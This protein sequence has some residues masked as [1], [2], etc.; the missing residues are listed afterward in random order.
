MST[1]ENDGPVPHLLPVSVLTG[2]LGSGKTTL[3]NALL[4]HPAMDETAV[5]INEFGAIGL[6]HLLVETLDDTTV[7]INDG[8]LCC[9]VRGDLIDAMR[10]LLIGRANGETPAF[11]RVV[12]ET[13]GLADPAPIVHTLMTDRLI[14]GRFRL[15]GVITTVDAVNGVRTLDEHD[16]S[17]KQAAVADRLLLTKTDLAATPAVLRD[18]LA[19]LNP[20]APCIPVEMGRVDPATLFDAGLYDPDTKSPDVRRWLRAE[21]FDTGSDGHHGHDHAHDP[22]RHDARIRAFCVTIDRPVDW[23]AFVPWAE[24]LIQMRGENL[25]RL[26]G[27]INMAGHDAP[28]ALHGVQH[29]FHPLTPLPAWPD[30]DRRSKLVFVT[31]DLGRDVIEE[32]L[33]AFLDRDIGR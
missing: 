16:E 2:F 11:R 3:L 31:R 22:N 26:K 23:A 25:L 10:R 30:G 15:D 4:A 6:D 7:L 5:L 28:F 14:A 27:V 29:V 13:T 17:V 19:R 32:S 1:A 21:A 8:C 24:M 33:S 12:I 18:R 9:T 20:G